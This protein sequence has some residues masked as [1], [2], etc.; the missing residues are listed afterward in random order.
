[1][2]KFSPVMDVLP[3]PQKRLWVELSQ[4]PT[5]FTLYG[6]TALALQLGH[7]E[8]IDFDFFTHQDFNPSKLKETIPYLLD[9]EL[10]QM[11]ENTLTCRVERGGAVLVSYFGGRK[12]GLAD[13]P[14]YADSNNLRIAS[15]RDV[16]ATKLNTIQKRAE[17]KDYIDIAA[18]LESGW[19][20][21]Q[22]CSDAIEV[23]GN[24]FEPLVAIKALGYHADLRGEPLPDSTSIQISKAIERI[25]LSQIASHDRGFDL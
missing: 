7:R 24:S 25:D 15:M 3:K 13:S 20:I 22:G 11:E 10:V 4:T 9:A 18:G 23:W 21:E 2:P 6:G 16:L 19:T 17:T 12:L 1:M 5:H 14:L 8:S